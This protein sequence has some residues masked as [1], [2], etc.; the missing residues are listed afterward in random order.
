MPPAGSTSA[1]RGKLPERVDRQGGQRRDDL[2][3]EPVVRAL[4]SSTLPSCDPKPCVRSL[5]RRS[6]TDFS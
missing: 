6:V 5:S 2:P 4:S 1:A 3:H